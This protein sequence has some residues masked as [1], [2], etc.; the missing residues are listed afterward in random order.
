LPALPESTP[1][2]P[3]PALVTGEPV[4][5]FAVPFPPGPPPV[6]P[7][8]LPPTA[9]AP[10]PPADAGEVAVALPPLLP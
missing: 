1:P 7:G 3:P 5:E 4:I 10:P 6:G 2:P 9:P 8:V